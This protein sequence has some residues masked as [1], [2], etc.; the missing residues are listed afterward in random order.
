MIDL[1]GSVRVGRA[2][3]R[4]A[5][6]DDRV[7]HRVGN[8]LEADLGGP[9]DAALCFN[10]IHHLSPE[11]IRLLFRRVREA[12]ASEGV[13]A[14]LDLFTAENYHDVAGSMLGLFFYLQSG[15]QDLHCSAARRV[16]A[17]CRVRRTAT[18][19]NSTHTS[20]DPVCDEGPERVGGS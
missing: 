1:P 9:Y 2:I 14:V 5:G 16:D 8:V 10:L 17:R 20:T 19:S 4:D 13:F 18:R 6:M 7:E 11:Q 12:M 3:V 15:T